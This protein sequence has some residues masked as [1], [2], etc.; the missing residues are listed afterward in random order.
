MVPETVTNT[1]KKQ[2]VQTPVYPARVS[3]QKKG[4][5]QFISHLD[6]LRTMKKALIRAEIPVKYSEGFNP[7]PKISFGLQLSIGAESLCEYM[8]LKLTEEPDFEAMTAALRRNLTDEL[9]VN[10]IYH[11]ERPLTDIA[12]SEY[13]VTFYEQAPDFSDLITD[14]LRVMKRTKSGEKEVDIRPAIVKW[15]QEG[16]SLRLFLAAAQET[17]LNPEYVVR[18]AGLDDYRILRTQVYLQDGVT[19]FR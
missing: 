11:P 18:L 2:N 12:F 9:Y 5:L 16:N 4:R 14:P 13:E 17:Y 8:D 19:V 15:E 3:F 6:L 7:H 10:E 1:E